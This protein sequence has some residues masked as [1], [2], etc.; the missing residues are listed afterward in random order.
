MNEMTT[1]RKVVSPNDVG[2]TAT[3]QAGILI[4]KEQK[5]LRFFPTLDAELY[6]PRQSMMFEDPGGQRWTFSFIYYNNKL[7]GQG[8]RNEYRLTGMTKFMRQ[9]ALKP[10]DSI[11]FTRTGDDFRIRVQRAGVEEIIEA[12]TRL[13]LLAGWMVIDD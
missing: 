12:P 11:V 4:P 5:L 2:S 9:A 7:H 3:H 8:T 1:I 10:G 6:N 13:V